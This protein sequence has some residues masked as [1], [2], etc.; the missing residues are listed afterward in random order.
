MPRQKLRLTRTEYQEHRSRLLRLKEMGIAIWCASNPSPEP[1]RFTL[2]QIDHDLANIYDFPSG[3]VAVVVHAKL[4][5]LVSGILITDL[6]MTTPW[7]GPQLDLS[8]P[9]DFPYYEDLISGL[10]QF[11]PRL[12]NDLLMRETPLHC[13]QAEGVI[14]AHGLG[15]VPPN[16]H[17]HTPVTVKL[18]VRDERRNEPCFEFGVRVDRSMKNK[19]ER[20]LRERREVAKSAKRIP[21]FGRQDQKLVDQKDVLL[22]EAIK[23]PHVI[24]EHDATGD[25]RSSYEERGDL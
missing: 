25:A 16:Y 17:D 15:S 18:L 12:L 20:E 10:P 11:P 19:Y 2:E 5:V 22:E 8:D 21:I 4:K 14:V 6:E 7:D 13:R 3:Y 1:E 23:R 24:R 9:R